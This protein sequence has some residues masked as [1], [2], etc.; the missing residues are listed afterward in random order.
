[1]INKTQY[2]TY[3]MKLVDS[4]IELSLRKVSD[5]AFI[6]SSYN[7]FTGEFTTFSTLKKR[8]IK[9]LANFFSTVEGELN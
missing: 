2:V 6:L 4:D 9:S 3:T 1:M 8:D 5:S 7:I